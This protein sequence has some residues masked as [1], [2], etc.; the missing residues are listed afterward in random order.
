MYVHV[1]FAVAL[2]DQG[3]D[4]TNGSRKKSRNKETKKILRL[5]LK[6]RYTTGVVGCSLSIGERT[7]TFKFSTEYDRP[8][9][10]FQNIVSE[11]NYNSYYYKPHYSGVYLFRTPL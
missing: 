6:E 3:T 7:V 2:M 8:K 11:N 10:I 1:H 4:H 9:D 5:K